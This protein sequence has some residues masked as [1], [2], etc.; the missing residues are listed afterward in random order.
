[1]HNSKHLYSSMEDSRTCLTSDSSLPVASIKSVRWTSGNARG[2][3]I[4]R[5]ASASF[6]TKRSKRRYLSSGCIHAVV[7]L[8]GGFMY[9]G[10]FM[11]A[12]NG[13]AFIRTLRL[14]PA[15]VDRYDDAG[16]RG[17]FANLLDQI[18]TT[19]GRLSCWHSLIAELIKSWPIIQRVGRKTEKKRL[20]ERLLRLSK[21]TQ[22]QQVRAEISDKDMAMLDDIVRAR[23]NRCVR[24]IQKSLT[25][26]PRRHPH[27]ASSPVRT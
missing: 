22:W 9:A 15:F 23:L 26:R 10:N 25:Q 24:R 19:L 11:T 14:S 13:T 20:A 5:V 8:R 2:S 6:R 3:D 12:N 7:T 27:R 4:L 16:L 21:E 1:M 17:L 18:D